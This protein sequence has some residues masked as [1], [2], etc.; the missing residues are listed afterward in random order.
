MLN[1]LKFK[2]RAKYRDGRETDLT[3]QQAYGLYGAGV[4][5]LIQG[6]GGTFVFG[7]Q[8]NV[9]LIGDGE[10]QWD[11]VAIVKYPSFEAFTKMTASEAYQEVHVHRD[12]GLSHQLLIN[13]LDPEQVA[14]LAAAG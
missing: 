9:L 14:K 7:G 12:A 13:C 6:L 3:G 11:T 10:L 2:E 1:L 4:A 5:K 8:A